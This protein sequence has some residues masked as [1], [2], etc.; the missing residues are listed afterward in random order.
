MRTTGDTGTVDDGYSIVGRG[1]TIRRPQPP[2]I[3]SPPIQ[4]PPPAAPGPAENMYSIPHVRS[5]SPLQAPQLPY[6]VAPSPAP[7]YRSIPGGYNPGATNDNDRTPG[8]LRVMNEEA[9]D[10]YYA[11]NQVEERFGPSHG[12]VYDGLTAGLDQHDYNARSAPNYRG[13]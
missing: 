9:E 13:Y 3:D 4:M 11:N 2:R 1:N 6:A 5:S 7:S 12:G 8:R 10:E